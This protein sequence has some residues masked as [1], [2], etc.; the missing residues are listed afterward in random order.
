MFLPVMYLFAV[1]FKKWN[2]LIFSTINSQV[3]DAAVGDIAIV[4]NRIKA[5]DFTLPFAATGLVIVA[6]VEN[7]TSSGWVFIKPFSLELW[8]A[9]AVS[10][11]IIAVVMW[12]L[13][14]RVNDDF[15]GP[16]QRQLRTMF[17]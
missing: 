14:H 4:S 16:P 7:S 8:C 9:T 10:F 6:P 1:S 5:V 15:R 11:V 2:L 12:M 13:E 3:L 17:L